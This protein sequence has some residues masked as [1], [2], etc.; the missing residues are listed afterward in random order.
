M[1]HAAQKK[2]Y[3]ISLGQNHTYMGHEK[4]ESNMMRLYIIILQYKWV[5]VLHLHSRKADLAAQYVILEAAV[6]QSVMSN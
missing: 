6:Q 4:T 1:E 3:L 2:Q 5:H